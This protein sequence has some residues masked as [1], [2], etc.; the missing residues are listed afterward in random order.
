MGEAMYAY[1]MHVSNN[2]DSLVPVVQCS[3]PGRIPIIVLCTVPSGAKGHMWSRFGSD[4]IRYS[5][6]ACLATAT[7]SEP[8]WNFICPDHLPI[9][10]DHGQLW[11]L[12]SMTY[13]L[14][15]SRTCFS[16]MLI[17]YNLEEVL[18]SVLEQFI[19]KVSLQYNVLPMD[20]ASH[21]IHFT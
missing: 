15:A 4:V 5:P 11:T 13:S 6:A 1:H 12:Y 9:D 14:G 8:G 2:M 20:A 18:R 7:K 17:L 21:L 16:L 3:L 19:S 10:P